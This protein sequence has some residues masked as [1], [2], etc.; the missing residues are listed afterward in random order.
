MSIDIVFNLALNYYTLP[1]FE[2]VVIHQ[3]DQFI[4]AKKLNEDCSIVNI[5]PPDN[6]RKQSALVSTLN[7]LLLPKTNLSKVIIGDWNTGLRKL[8]KS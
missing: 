3:E 7:Q 8:D 4:V 2:S 1:L 6:Y 5:Y